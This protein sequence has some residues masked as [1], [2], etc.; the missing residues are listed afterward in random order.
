MFVGTNICLSRQNTFCRD[1]TFVAR[2]TC[3]ILSRQKTCFVAT[4]TCLFCWTKLCIIVGSYHK[5]HFCR[6]VILM[7]Q[8]FCHDN[9]VFFVATKMILV[10]APANNNY[11]CRDKYSLSRKLCSDK[12]FCRDKHTF[13]VTSILLSRQK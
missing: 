13:V 2:N 1:K 8:T 9:H 6:N 10:A 11:V 12:I 4:N 3:R 5:Y 7:R